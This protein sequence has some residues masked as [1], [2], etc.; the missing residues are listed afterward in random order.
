MYY[1][2]TSDWWLFEW[3]TIIKIIVI[4]NQYWVSTYDV[5]V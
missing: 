1:E 4:G 2:I 5:D 3:S